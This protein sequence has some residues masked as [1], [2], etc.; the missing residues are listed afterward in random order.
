MDYQG[1]SP[2]V[3]KWSQYRVRFI[4]VPV[5]QDML[6]YQISGGQQMLELEV[7][8]QC[9]LSLKILDVNHFQLLGYSSQK[10]AKA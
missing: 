6:E 7:Y 5:W 8:F 10:S 1:Q 3:D 4:L 2:P 9:T